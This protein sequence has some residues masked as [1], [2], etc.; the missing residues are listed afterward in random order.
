VPGI[1]IVIVW[2]RARLVAALMF[3]AFLLFS[4]YRIRTTSRARKRLRA[5]WRMLKSYGNAFMRADQP[6]STGT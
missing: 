4:W 5:A 3:V 6:S 1:L 2:I